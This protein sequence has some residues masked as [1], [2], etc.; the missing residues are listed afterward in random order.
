M[1]CLEGCWKLPGKRNRSAV[2]TGYSETS[3]WIGRRDVGRHVRKEASNSTK[4]R[5]ALSFAPS[6]LYCISVKKLVPITLI[7]LFVICEAS[8]K[9]ASPWVPDRGDGVGLVG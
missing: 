3:V 1:T 6:L 4:I 5:I 8:A 9:A 7:C 2:T